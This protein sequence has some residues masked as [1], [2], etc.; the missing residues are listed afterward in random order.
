MKLYDVFR[1]VYS[2]KFSRISFAGFD[3][4]SSDSY[5]TRGWQNEALKAQA[6]EKYTITNVLMGGGKTIYSQCLGL[7]LQENNPNIKLIYVVPQ[8]HIGLSF[9]TDCHINGKLWTTDKFLC[10][11]KPDNG[12]QFVEFFQDYVGGIL[13][14]THATLVRNW[15]KIK[16]FINSDLHVFVDEAHHISGEDDESNELG[17]FCKFALDND[18]GLHLMTATFYRGDKCA[19]IPEEYSD[20]FNKYVLPIDEYISKYIRSF[21][22]FNY[23]F[24]FA[25]DPEFGQYAKQVGQL[26]KN[27]TKKTIVFIPHVASE[28]VADKRQEVKAIISGIVG[29]KIGKLKEDSDGIIRI[30][31]K[32]FIN[33]VDENNRDVK[34]K[35]M[36]DGRN[37]N[38]DYIIALGMFKEGSNWT[39][40]E[41]VV[42]CGSR[43]SV[44]ETVQIIGRVLRDLDKGT[45]EPE[46]IQILAKPSRELDQQALKE[47]VNDNLCYIGVSLLM[48]LIF[49]APKLKLAEV[50][51]EQAKEYLERATKH[52]F[53]ADAADGDDE[54]TQ[55]LMKDLCAMRI[56]HDDREEFIEEAI[57]YM[58]KEGYLEQF[59][60]LAAVQYWKLHE[61]RDKVFAK[62]NIKEVSDQI[63]MIDGKADGWMA[64]ILS[65]V[66]LDKFEKIREVLRYGEKASLEEHNNFIIKNNIK[67]FTEWRKK[68]V[69]G[70]IPIQFYQSPHM[71]P[72]GID[73]WAFDNLQKKYKNSVFAEMKKL[74]ISGKTLREIAKIFNCD[75]KM[76]S[77]YLK[78]NKVK[79]R[80]QSL[81]GKIIGMV[82]GKLT[83]IDE[84][85]G[86]N[87]IVKCRCECGN[88]ISVKYNSLGLDKQFSC[89]CSKF[90][91]LK[92]I[93]PFG[94]VLEITNRSD[95]CRKNHI[96]RSALDYCLIR[97]EYY[98]SN[99]YCL[100]HHKLVGTTHEERLRKGLY[101][102]YLK[103]G[104]DKRT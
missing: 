32:S 46:V 34:K 28:W 93:D 99:G 88:I 42:I 75:K 30:G 86:R 37:L 98:H 52:N 55:E 60:E 47:W 80:S 15:T 48:E 87:R 50:K 83:I 69:D 94:Q 56:G 14:C 25:V 3:T 85:G 38:V 82:I 54:R 66:G 91:S 57:Q 26:L 7:K 10:E 43:N 41:K 23:Q 8:T 12:K 53:I 39:H 65:E 74:Y 89:G 20:L 67:N 18:A 71:S 76:V 1:P 49:D 102:K 63:N 4:E 2:G 97:K 73:K 17:K 61:R 59:A 100:Y 29:K 44:G 58:K 81:S 31:K 70:L 21:D 45:K 24:G 5:K 77:I 103:I 36:G 64:N 96:S 19:I 72:W 16:E 35:T 9:K 22:S 78:R 84:G 51:G 27:N 33:L 79:I 92:V 68:A 6:G 11:E 62:R 101:K 90:K 104:I 95:F 40:A 13:V